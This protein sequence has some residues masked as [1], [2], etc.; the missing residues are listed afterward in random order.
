MDTEVHCGVVWWTIEQK[1]GSETGLCMNANPSLKMQTVRRSRK[2]H[3]SED[4]KRWDLPTKKGAKFDDG[5]DS[6]TRT[7][8]VK[9]VQYGHRMFIAWMTMPSLLVREDIE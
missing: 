3:R 5:D 1:P 7:S 8:H 2:S 9:G 6:L 4:A